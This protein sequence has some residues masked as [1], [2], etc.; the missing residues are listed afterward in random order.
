MNRIQFLRETRRNRDLA[1]FMPFV[2]SVILL[3][4]C[5]SDWDADGVPNADDCDPNRA[6]NSGM[7]SDGDC[8]LEESPPIPDDL[9]EDQDGF[10]PVFMMAGSGARGTE[11]QVKQLA[12][13]R[14]LMAK[15]KKSMT[16]E[17]GEIIE[18][19]T[20]E[21]LLDN[22]GIYKRYYEVQVINNADEER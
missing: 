2:L 20:H 11:D 8:R 14:G 7:I 13:M 17:K 12:G 3:A 6:S 22:C 10:N 4:G 5:S 1:L 19:G 21:Q 9:E 18:S 15:P 16:G